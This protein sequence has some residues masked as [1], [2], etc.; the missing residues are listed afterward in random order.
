MFLLNFYECEF[1]RFSK[2]KRDEIY[3][4]IVPLLRNTQFVLPRFGHFYFVVFVVEFNIFKVWKPQTSVH[5][6]PNQYL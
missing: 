2:Q 4:M 6:K 1:K 5:M 3:K